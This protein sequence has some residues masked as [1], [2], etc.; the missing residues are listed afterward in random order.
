MQREILF[1]TISGSRLYKFH[2][3]DSDY[4]YF[5]VVSNVPRKRARHAKQKIVG[6][7]DSLVCDLSTFM[8]DCEKGVPQALE[9][10]YSP[11]AEVDMISEFR[12]GY[13]IN[14][15]KVA[16]TYRRTINNFLK[17]GDFKRT[18]HAFRLQINLDQALRYGRIWPVLTED[19]I[20]W[21][22]RQ[23]HDYAG[24]VRNG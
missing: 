19:E 5:T 17:S 2:R 9:A 21:C 18:R 12:A 23:V 6:N 7:Q 15:A 20:E 10:M 4:D 14:T 1:R 24:S 16:N 8:Q 3:T 22:T 13:R 11:I